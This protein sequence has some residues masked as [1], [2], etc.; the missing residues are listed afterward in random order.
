MLRGV[1]KN[2]LAVSAPIALTIFLTDT[3]ETHLKKDVVEAGGELKRRVTNLVE[4]RK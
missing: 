2:L 1:D 4:K 3:F